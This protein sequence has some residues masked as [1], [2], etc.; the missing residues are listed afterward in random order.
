MP[1]ASLNPFAGILQSLSQTFGVP[2]A[3]A[4]QNPAGSGLPFEVMIPQPRPAAP[5]SGGRTDFEGVSSD[6]LRPDARAVDTRVRMAGLPE[7][8]DAIG[9]LESGGRY[10]RLGPI[11][12]KLGRALGK[13]QVM[14]ANVGPWSREVLGREVS[15]Q[16]FL[17][18]PDIQDAIFDAKFGSYANKYGPSGAAQAWFAGEG[19]IGKN[20]KDSLGTSTDKYAKLFEAELRRGGYDM[21]RYAGMAD[22]R[23]GDESYALRSPGTALARSL[24][25]EMQP[26]GQKLPGGD[27]KQPGSGPQVEV[28]SSEEQNAPDPR[29]PVGRAYEQYKVNRS[30]RLLRGLGPAATIGVLTAIGQSARARRDAELEQKP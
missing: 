10:D 1:L 5:P 28:A 20:R 27:K 23:K 8:R 30:T 25:D 16:E 18:N 6:D 12:P 26:P 7:W 9:R 3:G 2:Q 22:G 13:Y 11:H 17:R 29:T 21:G 14:E 4:P 19:G 24:P 15:P